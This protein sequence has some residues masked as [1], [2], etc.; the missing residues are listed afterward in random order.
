MAQS[1][2]QSLRKITTVDDLPEGQPK[3]YRAGGAT[4]VLLRRGDS[5]EAIDGS[6]VADADI[7][8]DL[9]LKRI[10]E[11]VAAGE[12]KNLAARIEDGWAWV[13]LDGCEIS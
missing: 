8:P 4:V 2:E 13:C 1:N 10:M 7:R 12:G 9:R 3:I 6:C 5:L 11:C